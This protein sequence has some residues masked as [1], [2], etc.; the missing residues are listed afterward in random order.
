MLNVEHCYPFG[1]GP[2]S[3][4]IH[5]LYDVILM[6]DSSLI[7]QSAHYSQTLENFSAFFKAPPT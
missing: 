5:Y 4:L 7:A 3:A 6:Y 2:H 1:K